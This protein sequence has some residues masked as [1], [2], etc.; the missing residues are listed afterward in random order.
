MRGSA[1]SA[2]CGRGKKRGGRAWR[3]RGRNKS[4]SCAQLAQTR[5]ARERME[6]T[7][8]TGL[9][10][11]PGAAVGAAAGREGTRQVSSL[12]RR[13][14][15]VWASER[16]NL[17]TAA[18]EL[19]RSGATIFQASDTGRRVVHVVHNCDD[20]QGAAGRLWVGKKLSPHSPAP[21]Y[22]SG[23][24]RRPRRGCWQYRRLRVSTREGSSSSAATAAGRCRQQRP[25][26]QPTG[27]TRAVGPTCS[28][29]MRGSRGRACNCRTLKAA[30][31][32]G[33]ARLET[34]RRATARGAAAK[35]AQ[36][37]NAGAGPDTARK[38]SKAGAGATRATVARRA[39]ARRE[40][41]ATAGVAAAKRAAMVVGAGGNRNFGARGPR[42]RESL[43]KTFAVAALFQHCADWPVRASPAH[44]HFGSVQRQ[45][46][47]HGAARRA[48][49][50]AAVVLAGGS[51]GGVRLLNTACSFPRAFD[52]SPRRMLCAV[53][54]QLG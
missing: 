28:S 47:S 29:R 23:S 41:T 13:S 51:V 34:A 2:K 26:S 53:F 31:V 24:D 39:E 9:R 37:M 17:R 25:G 38:P 10:Q 19:R 11:L 35:L 45:P 1:T 14:E 49:R 52:C 18:V 6:A 33:A 54:T 42:R 4:D 43:Q 12:Q 7:S 22:C 3:G 15:L 16:L 50:A 46:A 20:H 5:N 40:V 8:S 48:A 30:T 32:A 27:A 44:H 21:A 36:P